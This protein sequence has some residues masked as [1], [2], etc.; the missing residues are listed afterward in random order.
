MPPRMASGT[1]S[2]APVIIETPTTPARAATDPTDRSMPAVI[3]TSVMPMAM[4]A[5]TAVCEPMLKRL[6]AERKTGE[7]NERKAKTTM[8]APAAASW[9]TTPESRSRRPLP[10]RTSIASG[11]LMRPPSSQWRGR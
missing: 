4:T 3:M 11:L 6:S 5:T 2:P 1:G 9:E 8:S 7:A 10:S